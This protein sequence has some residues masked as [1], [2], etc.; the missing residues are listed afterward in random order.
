MATTYLLYGVANRDPNET[1]VMFFPFPGD[2]TEFCRDLP[3]K[4]RLMRLTG[5]DYAQLEVQYDLPM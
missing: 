2:V 1:V 3:G 4:Y 5:V